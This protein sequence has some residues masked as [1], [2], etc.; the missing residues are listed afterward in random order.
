VHGSRGGCALT[1][2]GRRLLRVVT[3]SLAA[4]LVSALT[5]APVAAA[6]VA[7]RLAIW[8]GSAKTP[9]DIARGYDSQLVPLL[10]RH[11]LRPSTTV[12]RP[13]VDAVLSRLLTAAS[14]AAVLTARQALADDPAWLS[15]LA[16]VAG[17]GS[18]APR[19]ELSLYSAA[20]TGGRVVSTSSGH[21][22]WQTYTVDDGLASG[23]VYSI[24]QAHDG[25]MY[26]GTFDGLSRYDGGRWQ[27]FT[28]ADGLGANGVIQMAEDLDGQLWVATRGGGVSRY[29]GDTWTTFTTHDGLVHDGVRQIMRD[30][31]GDLW[32]A[33]RGGVS[34]YDGTTWTNFTE[35]EGLVDDV[36]YAIAQDHDGD[37]WFGTLNHG[38][39]RFDGVS[40][41][42]YAVEDG[43][44][45]NDV[46][47]ILVDRHG[48]V[49]I[50]SR[51]NGVTR[52]DGQSFT[53]ILPGDG[54]GGMIS[55]FQDKD[56]SLW[57]GHL[58]GVSHYD[59][60]GVTNYT[61]DD[62]LVH[63][64]TWAACR[65][66]DGYLWFGTGG[67]VSR[68][69]AQEFRTYT[70]EDGLADAHVFRLLGDRDGSV[71]AG[72][73]NGV[74]HFDGSEWVSFGASDGLGASWMQSLFQDRD[75][76]Y[77][78]G[79]VG[80]LSALAGG[81][82]TQHTEADGLPTTNMAM[83]TSTQ[84]RRGHLWIGTRRGASRW[85]GS[86]WSTL[87][88]ADGLANDEVW[89]I[90]EDREGFLWF[91]TANGLSR[92]DP[93][94]TE[95][96]FTTFGPDQGLGAYWILSLFVDAG[97]DLWAGTLAGVTRFS[98]AAGSAH[99]V[100][101]HRLFTKADGLPSSS[102]WSIGQGADGVMWFGTDAGVSR[103]D[104]EVFQTMSRQDGLGANS[105][106]AILDDDDGAMWFATGNG[107]T[108][109]LP[110]QATPPPVAIHDIV[111]D[112]RY[113]PE[114]RISLPGPVPLISFEVGSRSFKTRP[115]AMI[116]RY[117][118]VGHDDGWRMTHDTRLEYQDLPRGDYTFE[119]VAVDRD[120]TYSDTPAAVHVTVHWPYGQLAL[121]LSL[122]V[123]LL[124]VAWQT[125]RV[126]H[127][128]RALQRTN[129]ALTAANNDLEGR[130]DELD[131]ARVA[132]ESASHAKSLFL[133]NMSHEIRTPMNAIL[134]YAQILRR[135][136][137]LS[138][139]QHRAVDTIQRSGDHL[140]GLIN[141]VLDISKIEVG[142]MELHDEDF[143]LGRT[144]E[145]AAT[146]FESQCR[147]KGI[148]WRLDAM[149][150]KGQQVRGDE[151]KLRQVL[152]NLLGN[153][154]KFTDEGQVSLQVTATDRGR[155]RF[156]VADTG[157]GMPA[158]EQ[159]GL[160]TAF[161]Q[162]HSGQR[163]GGTGLGLAISQRQVQLMDS[164]IEVDSTPGHGTR[165]YFEITLPHVEGMP[166]TTGG[167]FA[168][169]RRLAVDHN[170]L[171]LVA[172][173]MPDNREILAQMLRDLGCRVHTAAHG[174]E[175][176]A[177]LVEEAPDILFLD[178]RM[179]VLDGLETLKALRAEP[180]WQ[181]V[182][183]VAISASVL[184]HERQ[185][186]LEAGFD[187][188]IDKPFR[189]E[190]ICQ[191]LAER[192]GVEF[193]HESVEQAVGDVDWS[194]LTLSAAMHTS[195]REAAEYYSVTNIEE[196]LREME[197]LGDGHAQLAT[198]LRT[199]NQD[200]D[201]DGILQLL[202]RIGTD[203]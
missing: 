112:R 100:A 101:S 125:T 137:E 105:V 124:L 9:A 43:L 23:A 26:F 202:E 138:G 187:D 25:S 40:F 104:G 11:G 127:R 67:G 183:V 38:V 92:Y 16:Q 5:A 172:D 51:I 62:G 19:F 24:Y 35:A 14:P 139:N 117:R 4:V 102:V 33:T 31:D 110:L 179:P 2:A 108:R 153:A 201:M 53:A 103:F 132:A 74:S 152:I 59:G 85:D 164:R 134:G 198:Q 55:G 199:L 88:I 32:F 17:S 61:V 192:L 119:V 95:A 194:A 28:T 136:R 99:G 107:L 185:A 116:Y 154:V 66:R 156:E 68:Y 29:D 65:D 64:V 171:A 161:Q 157:P 49:W 76:T 203:G 78:F 165:F 7:A 140:L 10:A 83:S 58:G 20:A 190:R 181:S 200:Q 44:A 130:T 195:L 3:Q 176:L 36:V 86:Q 12:G 197:R 126:V 8:V 114:E 151:D 73:R 90:V 22:H 1:P 63:N 47:E 189:F 184:Q 148:T 193:D 48:I 30:R 41:T 162:G 186:Y 113:G 174:R 143:D 79:A 159:E 96:A 34:R 56:G 196:H 52:Y 131:S 170:V 91:G 13:T 87:T 128:D 168:G 71:W 89:G 57:F 39:S 123:A 27:T 115:E 133:A 37:L 129:L 144:V 120:L 167:D 155:F 173:D 142:R 98:L 42:T 77:W 121:T 169:V 82:W 69:N 75:G 141:D 46:W 97:G 80:A 177:G 106:Y 160:F 6:D 147:D 135:D 54:V 163:Q 93:S 175:V 122:G 45:S 146:M 60:D 50:G 178:I 109:F 166:R 118:L 72:T 149:D 21:G 150:T 145:T 158:A 70:Q 84:D 111:A 191:C 15:A 94:A 81:R 18:D 188:F 180:A 182:R